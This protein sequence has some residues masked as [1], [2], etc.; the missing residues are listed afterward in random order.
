MTKKTDLS[1]HYWDS[2]CVCKICGEYRHPNDDY[3]NGDY[4]KDPGNCRKRCINCGVV[5]Y[6][7]NYE[8]GKGYGNHHYTC[9]KCGHKG[10]AWTAEFSSYSDLQYGKVK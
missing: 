10:T 1:A 6:N 2:N 8:N 3:R 5:F 9:T 7:H 4:W